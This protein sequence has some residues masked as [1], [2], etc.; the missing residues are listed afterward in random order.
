MKMADNAEQA[1][2][3]LKLLANKNRLMILCCLQQGE[4]S[5]SQLNESV[6]LSQ[7]ALSQHL[8][9]L[10]QEHIVSTR[11]ESQT[12]YYR[13]CNDQVRAVL[14]TLYTLFCEE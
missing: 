9:V 7:S 14:N 4:L 13:L 6:P 12:I 10:R 1:Q 5:V 8:A 11:R 2:A 3:L